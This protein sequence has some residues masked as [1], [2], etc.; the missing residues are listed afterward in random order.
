[1]PGMCVAARALMLKHT[2]V[3]SLLALAGPALARTTAVGLNVNTN[4]NTNR[5]G[6]TA[7]LRVSTPGA[8]ISRGMNINTNINTNFGTGRGHVGPRTVTVRGYNNNTNINT[9]VV[10]I[11][12]GL[13][14]WGQAATAY[15]KWAG[16]VWGVR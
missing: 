13:K 7:R 3:V 8:V 1:M 5:Y 2:L 16:A 4:V 10:H 6:T 9:N 14:A 15:W 11:D 12:L